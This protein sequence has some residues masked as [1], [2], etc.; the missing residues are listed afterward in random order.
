MRNALPQCGEGVPS[1]LQSPNSDGSPGQLHC[2]RVEFTGDVFGPDMIGRIRTAT[3]G[4]SA[5]AFY[6][7]AAF[8]LLVALIILFL[9]RTDLKTAAQTTT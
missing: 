2:V 4:D 1:A 7:L 3:G 9:P 6:A 8:A 5:A